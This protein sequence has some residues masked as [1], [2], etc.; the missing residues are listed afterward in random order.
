M[1]PGIVTDEDE[2]AERVKG[3]EHQVQMRTRKCPSRNPRM[4]RRKPSLRIMRT[5]DQR[6]RRIKKDEHES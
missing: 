1:D 2:E 3:R 5:A 4:D 6:I